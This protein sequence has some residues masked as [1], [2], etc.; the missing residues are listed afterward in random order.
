LFPIAYLLHT[1][2]VHLLY[3][4][5]SGLVQLPL[6]NEVGAK[7]AKLTVAWQMPSM[8]VPKVA[9]PCDSVTAL[10]DAF[11]PQQTLMSMRAPSTGALL[12]SVTSTVVEPG[13]QSEFNP[14]A[15]TNVSTESAIVKGK[16]IGFPP[17]FYGEV[18]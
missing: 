18:L 2:T 5:L 16:R 17:C 13:A 10:L 9:N 14:K 3:P 6:P 7:P 15:P 1:C 8:W 4:F 12:Q 11:P